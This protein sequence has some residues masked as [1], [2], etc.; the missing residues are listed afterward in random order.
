MNWLKKKWV[1][2]VL[3][4]ALLIIFLIY[5]TP[6]KHCC[7]FCQ[8][9]KGSSAIE[10]CVLSLTALI[11]LLVYRSS[12]DVEEA[13]LL[14]QIR[15]ILSS[16]VNQDIYDKSHELYEQSKQKKEKS[17]SPHDD[18]LK[19]MGFPAGQVYNYMGILESCETLLD[20]DVISEDNFRSQFGYRIKCLV[21][22]PEIVEK[23]LSDDPDNWAVFFQLLDRFPHLKRVYNKTK[24]Q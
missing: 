1:T 11:A 21:G 6:L 16:S 4:L 18:D 17:S 19:L 13:K 7:F 23:E 12:C 22:N 10:I 20:N 8:L 24:N 14:L 15:E 5:I 3:M 9:L 2:N